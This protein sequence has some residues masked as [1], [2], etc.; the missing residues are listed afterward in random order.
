M[1][2]WVVLCVT[3][4]KSLFENVSWQVRF[5]IDATNCKRKR[6]IKYDENVVLR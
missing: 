2:C 6:E 1:L 4:R 3:Q 5:A